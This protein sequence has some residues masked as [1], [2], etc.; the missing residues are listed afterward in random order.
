MI[1][2]QIS[3]II[4]ITFPLCKQVNEL[5][6]QI[7]KQ[8]LHFILQDHLQPRKILSALNLFFFFTIK[9]TGNRLKKAWNLFKIKPF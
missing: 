5:M 6:E 3:C 1:L 7:L 4:I 2:H 8:T 9:L